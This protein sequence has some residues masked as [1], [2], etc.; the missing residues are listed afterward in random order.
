M[1]RRSVFTGP[2]AASL[3][4]RIGNLVAQDQSGSGQGLLA[5]LQQAKKVRG[6]PTGRSRAWKDFST[7][8][9]DLRLLIAIDVVLGFP[10]RV[11]RQPERYAMPSEASLTKGGIG[12]TKSTLGTNHW[13]NCA[14]SAAAGRTEPLKLSPQIVVVA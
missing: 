7:S 11:A 3:A 1:G 2:A 4:C 9:R 10:D 8:S 12:G 6:N 5:R 13:R 14:G